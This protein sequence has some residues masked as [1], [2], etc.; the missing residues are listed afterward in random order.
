[1]KKRWKSIIALGL[2]TVMCLSLAAC[3]GGGDTAGAGADNGGADSAAEDSGSAD[4]DAGTADSGAADSGASGD[5]V[6]TFWN[7]GTEGADKETYEMAIRQFEEN[8]TSGYTI[9]NIPTQNDKYKEKLVIAMSSGE[10]PDMYTSWSG[11]PMNEYIDSGYAQP[12]DD[13]YEKYNLKDRFMEGAIEQASYN[14]KIYAIPVKNIS[15][16]GIYYNKDLFEQYGVSVPTTVSELESACDTF[17]ANGIL[18]FT[19]ANG[20]KWT[21]SM[22]FQC[23]A[24]RKGGLEP[25]QKAAAGEGSF[26]DE[27]FVYAGE[28]IQEWVNKGYFPEGFNSMSEDDGQATQFFYTEE[29]AMYLIGSWKTASFKTDSDEAGNNFYDKVGWFS[30]PAVDGSDADPSIL[31]GTMGDQFISFNCTDEKLDAA[32]EFATYLSSDETVEY[33]VGA[34]LIPPVKGVEDLITDPI[35]K[36][37]IEASNK[38]AAVQLWYDQYLSPAVANAHLDGNQEVFGLTMTPEDANKKMQ[39]A[40]EE[41]L[42]E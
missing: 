26:E 28:K 40:M 21:G 41:D 13:L 34:S 24:A 37:M 35:S 14:G 39:Q 18:P 5:K 4:A 7:V 10:C 8:S 11:G 3:G 29:A 42:A 27:C 33:M 19:L 12:L 23:L 32:F 38:A 22:Y 6:I 25:F 9:E 20:P 31:C 2:S 16:A 15:I 1:M 30:F 17:L 36:S